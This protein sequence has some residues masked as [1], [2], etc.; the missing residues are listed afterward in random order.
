MKRLMLC[1]FITT[2]AFTQPTPTIGEMLAP[3]EIRCSGVNEQLAKLKRMPTYKA[4]RSFG[5]DT[6]RW[7]SQQVF[8]YN[9]PLDEFILVSQTDGGTILIPCMFGNLWAGKQSGRVAIDMKWKRGLETPVT[10]LPEPMEPKIQK[11]RK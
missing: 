1:F 5:G 4:A 3:V 8:N 9:P 7:L 6:A 11:K 10:D 2:P